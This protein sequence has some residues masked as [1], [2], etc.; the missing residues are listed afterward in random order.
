MNEL[1]A[2]LEIPSQV[3]PSPLQAKRDRDAGATSAAWLNSVFASV[4]QPKAVLEEAA[5]RL[6]RFASS[7]RREAA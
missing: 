6:R 1:G 5:F 7:Y 4:S 2:A 3:A